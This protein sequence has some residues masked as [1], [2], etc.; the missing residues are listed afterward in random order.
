MVS[1]RHVEVWLMTGSRMSIAMTLEPRAS[2]TMT[3]TL[4]KGH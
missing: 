3:F 4:L 2:T 1:K